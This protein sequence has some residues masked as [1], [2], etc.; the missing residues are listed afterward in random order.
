[1]EISL[2]S[3]Q[4]GSGE[5][6]LQEVSFRERITHWSDLDQEHAFVDTAAI[7]SHLDLVITTDNAMA[8]LAGALGQTVWVL[9]HAVADWRWLEAR[10]DS[11]WYPT[12]RLFRQTEAGNWQTVIAEVGTALTGTFTPDST[13][14]M[15]QI[16]VSVGEL[17]DKISILQIK[18]RRVQHPR[19][20]QWVKQELQQL[21]QCLRQL[22]LPKS[23]VKEHL[24]ALQKLNQALWTLEN[25]IRGFMKAQE[26]GASLIQVAQTICR[27]N[28][29]RSLLK[30][31][32]NEVYNSK[33]KEVKVY[34]EKE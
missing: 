32:I 1:P 3:L 9:L 7:V 26:E 12:M 5:A 20:R 15:P 23:K 21:N 2:V 4:K 27:Y 8:H 22:Q 34:T 31:K 25:Q 6:A 11:P 13:P 18:Y 30:R 17:L 24:G 19:Q 10:C 33:L 16:P 14:K 29:R 28:D